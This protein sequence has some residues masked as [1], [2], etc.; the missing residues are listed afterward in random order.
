MFR[1][2]LNWRASAS[3]VTGI[4]GHCAQQTN[5]QTSHTISPSQYEPG[6]VLILSLSLF[7]SLPSHS[8]SIIYPQTPEISLYRSFPIGAEIMSVIPWRFSGLMYMLSK[9][10]RQLG[11][12]YL[13]FL[14][15][16]FE[17]Y[18]FSCMSFVLFLPFF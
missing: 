4:I 8:A 14:H 15:I 9:T 18:S 5:K 10:S 12:P 13:S 11:S 7:H 16:V 1:L 17:F 2:A 3:G 6:M